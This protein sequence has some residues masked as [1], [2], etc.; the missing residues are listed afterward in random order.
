M[1]AKITLPEPEPSGGQAALPS[2]RRRVPL[3]SADPTTRRLIATFLP[4]PSDESRSPSRGELLAGQESILGLPSWVT[5]FAQE[6]EYWV[7]KTTSLVQYH[8]AA[9]LD[10]SSIW[11]VPVPRMCDPTRPSDLIL[12]DCPSELEVVDGMRLSCIHPQTGQMVGTVT[13]CGPAARL[14][15]DQ[16]E[17]LVPGAWVLGAA[18][19]ARL[20][21][22]P[23]DFP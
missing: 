12:L 22:P 10:L 6:L 3:T 11:A 18:W 2:F 13:V 8:Q 19:K 16:A 20:P 23:P 14:R 7:T 21:M 9:P 1:N 15:V 4:P 17:A 5:P